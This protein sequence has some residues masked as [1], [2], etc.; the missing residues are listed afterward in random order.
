MGFATLIRSISRPFPRMTVAA[1]SVLLVTGPLCAEVPRTKSVDVA[2]VLAVDVSR[3]VDHSRYILQLDG[4]AAALEN[5]ALIKG[6]AQGSEGAVAIT[7]MEFSDPD[8]Q[9]PVID[10]VRIA[11]EDDA[12]RMAKRIRSLHRTSNGLTGIGNA[13]LNAKNLLDEL[14]FTAT[15][16]IIDISGDGIS[17]IGISTTEARDLVVAAGITINGLPIITEEPSL[18][19]YYAEYVIGGP[20]AFTVVANGIQSFADAMRRKLQNELLTS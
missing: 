6:I 17:N 8:R 10:W 9:F 20:G 3:S 4:I 18:D 14:P 2:L 1:L 15:R 19:L 11:N 13:L 7:L 16:K 12:K 5:P